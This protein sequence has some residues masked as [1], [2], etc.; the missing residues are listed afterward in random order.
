MYRRATRRAGCEMRPFLLEHAGDLPDALRLAGGI[1]AAASTPHA[2]DPM[3]YLA[4][5]TTLLT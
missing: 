4:G 5:G 2:R 3:Q 1:P